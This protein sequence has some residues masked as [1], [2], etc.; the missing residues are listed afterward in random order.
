MRLNARTDYAARILIALSVSGHSMTTS[1]I[2]TRFGLPAHHLQKI[3]WMLGTMGIVRTTRGRTG[4]VTLA[5]PA[6]S[7]NLG[8]TLRAMEKDSALVECLRADGGA[9]VISPVCRL[10]GVFIEAREAFLQVLDR[11]T[12]ADVAGN[13]DAL[14]E[15]LNL[16]PD[17]GAV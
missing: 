12:L 13:R 4:G 5:Q 3:I 11:Y 7:I 15:L 10:R 1:E 14:A 17:D 8:H 16:S 2:A 6:Q 9:C